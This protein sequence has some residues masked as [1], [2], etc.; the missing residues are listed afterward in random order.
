MHE[1][2]LFFCCVTELFRKMFLLRRLRISCLLSK[3]GHLVYP[4][5]QCRYFQGIHDS[6][7]CWKRLQCV[8][9]YAHFHGRIQRKDPVLDYLSRNVNCCCRFEK[10]FSGYWSGFSVK[11]GRPL[12]HSSSLLNSLKGIG[13][14]SEVY[15]RFLHRWCKTQ[16]LRFSLILVKFLN[17]KLLTFIGT[18]CP[19]FHSSLIITTIFIIVITIIIT[20]I[21]KFSNLIGHQQA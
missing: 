19:C 15:H 9:Q 5:V 12:D 13:I 6:F 17:H 21:S 14:I 3:M 16:L 4:M 1:I 11:T 18:A 8:G 20:T 10:V 7:C 2:K